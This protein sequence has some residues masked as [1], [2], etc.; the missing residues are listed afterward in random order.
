M[1]NHG[2]TSDNIND[3]IITCGD[4]KKGFKYKSH[5]NRH[6]RVHTGEKPFKCEICDKNFAEKGNLNKNKEVHIV[7]KEFFP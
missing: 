4:C 5:F 3:K 6:K 7:N 1:D 2:S